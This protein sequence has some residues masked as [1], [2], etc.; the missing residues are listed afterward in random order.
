[1]KRN[2]S[3]TIAIAVFAT[4]VTS[5]AQT[6]IGSP[7]SGFQVWS[8]ANLNNSGAPY[9]D[10]ATA[11]YLGNP[12]SR[13]VGFCLTSSGD[14]QG[15]NSPLFA[16]GLS[17][18]GEPR[19]IQRQ[20]PAALAICWSTSKAMEAAS[21]PRCNSTSEAHRKTLTSSAGLKPTQ[22]APRSAQLTN[23]TK[24][25]AIHREVSCPIPSEKSS[26]SHPLNIL[27]SISKTSAKM[28]VLSLPS[29]ASRLPTVAQTTCS[30]SS[31]LI[32]VS[33]TTCLRL[34]G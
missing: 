4:G 8:A 33:T 16:P 29:L 28:A 1:M 15:I 32:P 25:R 18:F 3:L 24:A 26:S 23:S 5:F 20:I 27:A 19:T 14:C 6:V 12:T 9:W 17:L 31:P 22:P 13:N 2:K 30:P 10:A 11:N 7:G 34:Q 21:R